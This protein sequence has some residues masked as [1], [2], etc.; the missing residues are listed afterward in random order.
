MLQLD[1]LR[2]KVHNVHFTEVVPV[3]KVDRSGYQEASCTCNEGV[4]RVTANGQQGIKVLG[5][6]VNFL[7]PS[8]GH[9]GC[10]WL[11]LM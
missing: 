10:F 1:F 11:L 2:L 4:D 7:G 9:F 5:S 3:N 8:L 6:S